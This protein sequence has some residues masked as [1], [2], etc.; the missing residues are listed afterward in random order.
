[1]SIKESKEKYVDTVLNSFT[2]NES[3][4]R[5]RDRVEV[6]NPCIG[7][8]GAANNDCRYCERMNQNDQ[9]EFRSEDYGIYQLTEQ[10]QDMLKR[11]SSIKVNDLH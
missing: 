10:Q 5:K 9:K 3:K 1:M 11:M 2:V 6:E 4:L 7:C 8:F